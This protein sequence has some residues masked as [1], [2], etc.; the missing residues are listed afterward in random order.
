[1]SKLK[2][3]VIGAGWFA[4][5]SHIPVLATRDEVELDGVCRLGAADLARVKD[6]FGFAFASEDYREVLARKPDIVVVS[7][8]HALHYEQARAALE[9]GA[10]VM[11]EKPMTLDPGQ[12]WDLVRIAEEHD[13]HLLI[14]N[15]HNYL[16]HVADLHD[17]IADGLIGEIEHVACS[18]ISVTREVFTGADGLKR[19]DAAF[20]RPD[21]STWQDP[22]GGGGFAY[23][24]LSH[25]LALMY[26]LSGLDPEK[27]SALTRQAEGVD[28]ADAAVL[29]CAGG[30]T[31]SIS[32][33][34][35]MPQGERALMRVFLAGSLG[36][37][38]AEFDLD[39]C[40]IKLNDGTREMLPLK[41]GDWAVN[42]AGPV[43]A[44]ADLALGRGRNQS[45]GSIGALTTATIHAMLRSAAEDGVMMPVQAQ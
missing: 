18:F 14:A 2:A 42:S 37:I 35:A 40:E 26:Y 28:I 30:A 39:R 17:R 8:P 34:V 5:H 12:A 27:V 9:G 44:L 38:T 32:G 11:C 22:A 4:A 3:A 41:P 19:W 15:S 36:L 7:S 20:F 21:R 23:G 31:V 13:R 6:H 1:M 16:P 25:S 33:S 29:G 45:S 24:Q 10:H 43:D